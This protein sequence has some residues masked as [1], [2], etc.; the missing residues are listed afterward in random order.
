MSKQLR[1]STQQGTPSRQVPT[2]QQSGQAAVGQQQ[3]YIPA[4]QPATQQAA[5]S[6]QRRPAQGIEKS[7]RS[8][9]FLQ[10]EQANG[11]QAGQA[12]QSTRSTD[13]QSASGQ[14]YAQRS[15]QDKQSQ[16]DRQS[17]Q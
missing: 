12:E 2:S 6:Q 17:W 3:G 1:Q 13:Q 10:Q 14:L 8:Q 9:Q 4:E 11:P 15:Q 16:Q 7:G 5:T